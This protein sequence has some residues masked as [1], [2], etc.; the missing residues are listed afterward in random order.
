MKNLSLF[1][2]KLEFVSFS[3]QSKMYDLETG[4]NFQQKFSD[5]RWFQNHSFPPPPLKWGLKKQHMFIQVTV[6]VF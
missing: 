2:K 5:N 4:F 6:F 3:R 1:E